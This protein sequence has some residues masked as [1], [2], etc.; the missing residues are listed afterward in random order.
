MRPSKGTRENQT[1]PN[2]IHLV[3]VRQKAERLEPLTVCLDL[4]IFKDK[5]VGIELRKVKNLLSKLS[6]LGFLL[7]EI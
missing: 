5:L 3:T 1:K 6:Y 7:L 2:D 4:R